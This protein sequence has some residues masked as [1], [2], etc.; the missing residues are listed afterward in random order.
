M[1]AQKITV[2]V[3]GKPKQTFLGM[4]VRNVIGAHAAQRVQ[5]HRAIVRDAEGN[6]VGI[7]GA[8]YDGERL[9]IAPLDPQTFAA[10]I[11][12]RT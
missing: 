11:Q 5:A 3:N 12:K 10:E 9:T 8:L 1:K 4:C 6:V 2:Y 7:D